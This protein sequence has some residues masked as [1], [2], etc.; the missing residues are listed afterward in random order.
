MVGR[1][2]QSRP[3]SLRIVKLALEGSE[4]LAMLGL[5]RGLLWIGENTLLSFHIYVKTQ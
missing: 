3:Q 2:N 4:G 5:S 1:I